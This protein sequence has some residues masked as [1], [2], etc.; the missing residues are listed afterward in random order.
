ME[1]VNDW[2]SGFYGIAS[3]HN[4]GVSDINGWTLSFDADFEIQ[5]IWNASI[6]SHSGTQYVVEGVGNDGV[7]AP[8]GSTGFGFIA[9]PGGSSMPVSFVVNDEQAGSNTEPESLPE[10][11]PDPAPEPVPGAGSGIRAGTSTS[12]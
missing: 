4:T 9:T 10:A 5:Q 12:A 11:V 8:N 1:K 6:V 7:I 2:G 3:I